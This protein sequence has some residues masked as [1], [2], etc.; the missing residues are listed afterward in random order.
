VEAHR[1]LWE[2]PV[3]LVVVPNGVGAAVEVVTQ[4]TL[5]EVLC[6]AAGAV[7]WEENVIISHLAAWQEVLVVHVEAM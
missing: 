7:E 3:A 4:A 2:Q 5:E 6:M 1:Q